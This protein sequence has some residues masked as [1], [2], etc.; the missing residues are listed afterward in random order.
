MA[1]Q[2][3]KLLEMALPCF[4][5]DRKLIKPKVGDLLGDFKV[6]SSCT[7]DATISNLGRY[8]YKTKHTLEARLR[9]RLTLQR[10]A[11]SR[12]WCPENDA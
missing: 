12:F 6:P 3:D 11:A 2:G 4:L 5:M 7:G 1:A 9:G 8:I 10:Q